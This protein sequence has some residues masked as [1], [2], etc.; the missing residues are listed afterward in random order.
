MGNIYLIIFAFPY[1]LNCQLRTTGY[2]FQFISG[3]EEEKSLSV[4][5]MH[6]YHS[7]W[8]DY[9]CK[10]VAKVKG[11]GEYVMLKSLEE[12]EKVNHGGIWKKR[13]EGMSYL[14]LCSFFPLQMHQTP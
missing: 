3:F 8:I 7:C 4:Q 13:V 6:V 14:T 10:Y 9:D 2:S 11:T 12:A 1:S 5:L